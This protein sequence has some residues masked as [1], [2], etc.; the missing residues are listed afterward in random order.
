MTALLRGAILLSLCSVSFA[1]TIPRPCPDFP[2]RTSDGKTI[3]I[4]KY[5]GKVV[6]I[7]MMQTD[8]EACHQMLETI[9]QWQKEW[10]PRGFQV[11]AFA[12]DDTPTN[13]VPYAERYRFPFPVAHLRR[14]A[15]IKLADLKKTARPFVPYVMFVDWKGDVRFQYAGNDPILSRGVQGIR[16]IADGLLR[17]AADKSGPTLKTVP[18]G[19]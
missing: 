7:V 8:C 15:V 17:Q 14:D 16:G 12:I 2:I 13:V 5:H 10:E 4:S 11:L 3:R 18:A 6:M 1:Q 9:S 19:K